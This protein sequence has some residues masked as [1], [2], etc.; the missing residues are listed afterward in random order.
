LVVLAHAQGLGVDPSEFGV[1]IHEQQ[2]I[3]RE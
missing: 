2:H 1:G 3:K